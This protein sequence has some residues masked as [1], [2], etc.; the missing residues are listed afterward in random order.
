[1]E[2][3]HKP[4][5][6]IK[7][8]AFGIFVISVVYIAFVYFVMKGDT[9]PQLHPWEAR[10]TFGDAFGGLNAIFSGLAFAAVIIALYYQQR[11]T[12]RIA[13]IQKD[14]AE[15]LSTNSKMNMYVALHNAY[16]DEVKMRLELK[17]R[18]IKEADQALPNYLEKRIYCR[19]AMELIITKQL[20]SEIKKE[21]KEIEDKISKNQN[22]STKEKND[23][24]EQVKINKEKLEAINK[25]FL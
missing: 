10:G 7:Y 8:A 20:V 13:K 11:E 18:G 4:L 19:N 17:T 25:T 9:S 16:D 1:M 23:L 24:I 5:T 6:L 15:N 12:E 14:Q 22:I 2:N 3:Q 21:N